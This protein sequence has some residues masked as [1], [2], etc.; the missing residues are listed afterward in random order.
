MSLLGEERV[1]AGFDQFCVVE[2]IGGGIHEDGGA[3]T[4]CLS[5]TWLDL[6][7][8]QTYLNFATLIYDP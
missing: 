4:E 6:A 8:M 7:N 5:L 3:N 2:L 1:C